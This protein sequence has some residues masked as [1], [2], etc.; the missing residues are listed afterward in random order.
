MGYRKLY[1]TRPCDASSHAPCIPR[2]RTPNIDGAD[3]STIVPVELCAR[4]AR[5]HMTV[6]A[7]RQ[8]PTKLHELAAVPFCTNLMGNISQLTAHVE[9]MA[10]DKKAADAAHFDRHASVVEDISSE[11]GWVADWP[12]TEPFPK[13]ERDHRNQKRCGPTL[14]F[15]HERQPSG[16]FFRRR[17]KN[18]NGFVTRS[19]P[20][21]ADPAS[22]DGA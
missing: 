12:R 1:A 7:N 10:R 14:T 13:V 9:R 21:V 5:S 20:F 19:S 2:T 4:A 22:P 11:A 8:S 3:P 16:G 15:G 6:D 17:V 18:W